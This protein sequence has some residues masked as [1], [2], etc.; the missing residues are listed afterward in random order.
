MKRVARA[1]PELGIWE[2]PGFVAPV[3]VWEPLSCKI[4]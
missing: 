2:L 1:Q 3:V 4:I